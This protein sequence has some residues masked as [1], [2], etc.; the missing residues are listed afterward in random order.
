MDNKKYSL[1]D[2]Q[3][4]WKVNSSEFRNRY[5]GWLSIFDKTI[6]VVESGMNHLKNSEKSIENNCCF[7]LLSKILNHSI[8]SIVLLEKGLVIDSAL[9]ARNSIESI[10]LLNLFALDPKTNHFV[11]WSNGKEYKPYEVRQ[12]LKDLGS[13]KKNEVEVLIEKSEYEGYDLAYKWFSQITHANFE[14]MKY[15]IKMANNNI[16]VYIGGSIENKNEF[17]QAVFNT[18]ITG[19]LDSVIFFFAVYHLKFFEQIKD[20]IKSLRERSKKELKMVHRT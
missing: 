2:F 15:V 12:R 4:H 20:E 5:S 16:Q 13:I 1:K 11:E 3:N 19:I 9:C 14:S 18:I 8:S 7:L 10:L 17:V 6:G